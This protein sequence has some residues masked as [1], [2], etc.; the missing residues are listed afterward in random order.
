MHFPSSSLSILPLK[1]AQLFSSTNS[2]NFLPSLS[3]FLS[4]C[5][6][7]SD[8]PFSCYLPLSFHLQSPTITY[9]ILL[10]CP[11]PL[12]PLFC[13]PVQQ[14]QY[15]IQLLSFHIHLYYSPYFFSYLYSPQHYPFLSRF[16]ILDLRL[17]LL[18]SSFY[19]KLLSILSLYPLKFLEL[20]YLFLAS[21]IP[22]T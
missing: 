15:L 19:I 10:Q 20:T 8:S 21:C 2:T 6:F 5:L 4:L 7:S 3:I 14:V 16:Y 9:Y 1:I 11:N 22:R 12:L 18:R 17:D 13:S